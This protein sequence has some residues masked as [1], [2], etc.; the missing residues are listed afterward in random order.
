MSLFGWIAKN[1]NKTS[2]TWVPD[3]AVDECMTCAADFGVRRFGGLV[4]THSCGRRRLSA[5]APSGS[6]C[7]YMPWVVSLSTLAMVEP[8]APLPRVRQGRL[9]DVLFEKGQAALQRV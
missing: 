4:A 3:E 2:E 6:T 5:L 8:Q 7:V 9:R 1:K